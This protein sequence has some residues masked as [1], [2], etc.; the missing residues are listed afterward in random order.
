MIKSSNTQEMVGAGLLFL[1]MQITI[2]FMFSMT[3]SI[4]PALVEAEDDCI[5]IED[6]GTVQE[7]EYS[8]NLISNCMPIIV[9][10]TLLL[11]LHC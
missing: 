11:T 7:E 4:P 2:S 6:G 3:V 5:E 10:A 8:N 9:T 1:V